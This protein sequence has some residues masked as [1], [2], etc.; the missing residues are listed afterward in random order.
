MSQLW[1][2]YFLLNLHGPAHGKIP[3]IR[4]RLRIC[5]LK[6]SLI[7]VHNTCLLMCS[8]SCSFCYFKALNQNA[9]LRSRLSR[10]HS[11]STICDHVV[12]V[13]IIPSPDEVRLIMSGC[14]IPF[15]W[16]LDHCIYSPILSSYFLLIIFSPWTFVLDSSVVFE[17]K[18][19]RWTWYHLFLVVTV[20][21]IYFCVHLMSPNI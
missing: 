21:L 9:E 10:I 15:L 20:S 3:R 1:A 12:S 11:E 14:R 6:L 16:H 8:Y 7:F 18:R 17:V 4:E 13:N 2:I 19:R 5:C